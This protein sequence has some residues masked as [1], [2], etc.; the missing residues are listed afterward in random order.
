MIVHLSRRY[1]FFAS[2]RLHTPELT[3]E[4]NRELYGKCNNPHG[5]GHNYELEVTVRGSVDPVTGRAIDLAFLDQLVETE[6]LAPFRYR[7]LNTEIEAFRAISPTTENLATEVDRRLRA[8]CQQVEKIRIW[9][10][11]RNIC[12]V[13]HAS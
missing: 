8:R 3:D 9:E 11:D 6:I 12:E 4:V 5:H 7:N 2:H 1:R 13:R 10:T